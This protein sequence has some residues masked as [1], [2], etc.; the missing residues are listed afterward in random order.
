[1]TEALPVRYCHGC[2]QYDDHPRVTHITA[3]DRPELDKLYH[4]D[5][6][7]KDVVADPV[8]QP[9]LAATAEGKR[10]AEI[11]DLMT[12][13]AATIQEAPADEISKEA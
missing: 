2:K 11:R 12:A 8:L 10:G 1:M 5:C 7:P 4:Y 9:A 6:A 13:H 3:V